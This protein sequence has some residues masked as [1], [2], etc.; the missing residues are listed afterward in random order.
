[1]NP[2]QLDEAR[3]ALLTL[4]PRQ[5][6]AVEA[7]ADGATHTEAGEAAGVARETVSRWATRHPAFRAAL[8][9]HRAAL[10]DE[11][12]QAA[13]RLRRKALDAVEA[14]VDAGDT[15]TALA[16]LRLVPA[17]SARAVDASELLDDARRTTRM[18]MHG[19]MVNADVD[20]LAGAITVVRLTTDLDTGE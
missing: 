1:M 20:E 8:S 17:P 2:D 7:L 16:V 14:A 4:T 18:N 3:T 12:H 13:T 19:D 5:Q 10:A 9:L 11:H 15:P 6:A